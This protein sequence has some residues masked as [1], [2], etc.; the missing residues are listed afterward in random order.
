M[1]TLKK[2]NLVNILGICLIALAG[3]IT[4]S[5]S[6]GLMGEIEPPKSLLNK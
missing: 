6:L 1:K 5:A 3:I 2:T 4:T